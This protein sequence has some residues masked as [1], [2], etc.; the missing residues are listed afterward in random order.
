MY[1]IPQLII[2]ADSSDKFIIRCS[3][4]DLESSKHCSQIPNGS[5]W[6][7]LFRNPVI[8]KGYPLLARNHNEKGLEISL[9]VM[10][11]LGNA[12][13]AAVFNGTLLVKGFS[14]IFVPTAYAETSVTW[15]FLF[16]EDQTRM[17]YSEASR[18]CPNRIS[19]E[20]INTTFV[21]KARH[22]LGWASEVAV[23]T[24]KLLTLEL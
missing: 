6:Q 5:C 7:K 24:G 2:P 21:E 19:A 17:P 11:S 15:H 8:V 18:Q 16:N 23:Y 20:V 13:R 1:T 12:T 14:T 4:E 9:D 3:F 10:A 22:F